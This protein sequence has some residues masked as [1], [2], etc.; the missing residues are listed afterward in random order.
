MP[1]IG[2]RSGERTPA[3]TTLFFVL[4]LS[5]LIALFD[6]Y[7]ATRD[8]ATD[9]P[10]VWPAFRADLAQRR[11]RPRQ[12]SARAIVSASPSGRQTYRVLDRPTGRRAARGNH[13]R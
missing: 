11:A 12:A 2:G 3:L 6:R 9:V 10:T 1:L 4:L 8:A 5:L 13:Q 7:R